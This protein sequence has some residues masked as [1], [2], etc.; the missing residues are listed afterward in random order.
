ME[1]R[2]FDDDPTIQACRRGWKVQADEE[3]RIEDGAHNKKALAILDRLYGAHAEIPARLPD[4]K[5]AFY[6]EI[7][8]AFIRFC[9]Q[10]EFSHKP[11]VASVGMYLHMVQHALSQS[12]LVEYRD[13]LSHYCDLNAIFD[14]TK[15]PIIGAI[16]KSAR[17]ER[18]EA[19]PESRKEN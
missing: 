19:N 4:E 1:S 17:G 13:A 12:E 16:L 9:D 18:P 2:I 8:R 11:T 3:A 14:V 7:V 6:T 5:A 15:D 10:W